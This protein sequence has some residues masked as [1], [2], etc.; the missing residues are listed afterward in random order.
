MKRLITSGIS[1]AFLLCAGYAHADSMKVFVSIVPQKYFVQK[2]GGD[3]VDVAVMVEPGASPATYEPKPA[4]MAALSKARVYFAIGAPFEKVWL[5]KIAAINP[6]MQVVHTEE[7]IKKRTMKG[8]GHSRGGIKDPHVWLSPPAVRILAGNIFKALYAL[9]PV[10]AMV[11]EANF[12]KFIAEIEEI[13]TELKSILNGH[14][15]MQ[16]MVFHPAWGYFADA[17]GLKQLPI[18]IEGKEPKPAQLMALIEHARKR[19]VRI[20]FVQPHFSI[21]SAEIIAREIG[22]QVVFADPLAENWA[23]N[24][25]KQAKKIRTALK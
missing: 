24:L 7:G 3:L 8:H 20:I 11:Y 16:F 5:E 9:D 13:H 22:G 4:Q 10:N 18:E 15:G 14:V 12:H 23:D 21:K 17:Y 1:L 25:R 19:G 2:I 6:R